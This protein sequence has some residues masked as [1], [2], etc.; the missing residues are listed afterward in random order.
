[1]KHKQTLIIG[2]IFH[3]KVA[4]D[5]LIFLSNRARHEDD[6]ADNEEEEFGTRVKFLINGEG[7][8]CMSSINSHNYKGLLALLLG[9]ATNV[10]H[11]VFYFPADATQQ[12]LK[13][14]AY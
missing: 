3:I 9:I 4:R 2:R 5:V 6:N 11:D 7:R 12:F 10:C 1:M 14:V 8:T 13:N